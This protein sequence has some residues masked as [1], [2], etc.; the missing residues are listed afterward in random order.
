MRDHD[1]D[2]PRLIS[3]ES[4][5]D[6]VADSVEHQHVLYLE[7]GVYEGHATR[8][9]SQRLK[10]PETRLHGFDSFEGLP[11][12]WGPHKKGHFATGGQVPTIDD[13]RVQF[14]KGW[15]EQTLPNYVVLPHKVLVL[16]MDADL[17]S[18]TITVLRYLRPHI[19]KGTFIYFDEMHEMEHEPRAFDEFARESGLT[20]RAVAADRT[21][22][23]VFFE[24]CG[25]R[26][27]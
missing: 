11:D 3:R 9:W 26:E 19:R 7:F 6:Q 13:P 25:P 5:F 10:H 8:Y 4:V 18:S 1:F 20:F 16:L 21:L 12:A 15:F 17:Y 2:C 27:P 23:H 24:C 14:F 22:A